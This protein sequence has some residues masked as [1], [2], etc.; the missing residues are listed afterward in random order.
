MDFGNRL[1]QTSESGLKHHGLWNEIRE[2]R[3]DH[4]T[5]RMC[6]EVGQGGCLGWE[7]LPP[8][9]T[10]QISSRIVFVSFPFARTSGLL[11]IPPAISSSLLA[12]WLSCLQERQPERPRSNCEQGSGPLRPGS[13]LFQ[14]H[15]GDH[16][17]K[18]SPWSFP[19]PSQQLTLDAHTHMSSFSCYQNSGQA[20]EVAGSRQE[21]QSLNPGSA[22]YKLCQSHFTSVYL[23]FPLR[24]LMEWS[25]RLTGHLQ[26]CLTAST[27]GN[28][29]REAPH[30]RT[31]QIALKWAHFLEQNWL[32]LIDMGLEHFW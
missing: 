1:L 17:E 4:P 3:N 16:P 7:L 6:S 28:K 9:N 30:L 11:N 15:T 25:N 18:P 20:V 32:N 19:S 5:S 29:N 10:H 31:K 12:W 13:N 26:P 23:S 14:V 24:C 2:A 21:G 22:S 8:W 27:K